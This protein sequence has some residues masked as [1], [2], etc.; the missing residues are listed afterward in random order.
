MAECKLVYANQTVSEK[1]LYK[2]IN[3]NRYYN[4]EI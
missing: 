1:T 3:I 2:N 4:F